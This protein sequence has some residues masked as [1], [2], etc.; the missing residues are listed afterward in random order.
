[1]SNKETLDLI[2]TKVENLNFK[3][4]CVQSDIT[5]IKQVMSSQDFLDTIKKISKAKVS[6]H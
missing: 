4:E 6:H 2:K 1:M 5:L 3:L